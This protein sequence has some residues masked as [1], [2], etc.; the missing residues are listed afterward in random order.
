MAESFQ[1]NPQI[2]YK[3]YANG[4]GYSGPNSGRVLILK[5]TNTGPCI[6]RPYLA[7]RMW[8]YIESSPGMKTYFTLKKVE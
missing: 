7:R 6:L 4:W 8:S 2:N 3:D 1:G 5:Q